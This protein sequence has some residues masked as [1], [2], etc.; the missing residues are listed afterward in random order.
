MSIGFSIKA[1]EKLTHGDVI[2]AALGEEEIIGKVDGA[3]TAT[4]VFV[5]DR[6]GMPVVLIK[7]EGWDIRLRKL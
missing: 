7:T 2:I 1:W 6:S 4:E 3:P 5:L